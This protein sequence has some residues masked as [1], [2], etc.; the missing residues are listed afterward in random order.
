MGVNR[1]YH[2][3]INF[4]TDV[5]K[6]LFNNKGSKYQ[7]G[8]GWVFE[9]EHFDNTFFPINWHRAHD[10]LGDGCEV[11]FPVRLHGQ[12]KWAQTVYIKDSDSG[13]VTPKNKNFEEVCIVWLVKQRM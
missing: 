9:L 13:E 1:G 5:F 11:Q 10:R 8:P 3:T 2:I 12:L 7:H 4:R 6:F